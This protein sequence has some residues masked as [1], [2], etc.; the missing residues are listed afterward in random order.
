MRPEVVIPI[1]GAAIDSA[2]QVSS[3]GM[4][5][6]SMVRIIRE[7]HFGE[8]AKVVSL[9]EKPTKIPSEAK[10]RVVEIETIKGGEKMVLPRANVEIIEE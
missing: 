5:I 1:E 8:V 9:P 2:P 10:V 7:P 6:G 4:Q 3:T